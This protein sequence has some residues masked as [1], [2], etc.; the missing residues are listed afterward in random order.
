M[1]G[2]GFKYLSQSQVILNGY[3]GSGGGKIEVARGFFASGWGI[4]CKGY[5]WRRLGEQGSSLSLIKA[6]RQPVVKSARG[7]DSLDMSHMEGCIAQFA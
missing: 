7:G 5:E 3:K 6:F 1:C 2:F 4:A